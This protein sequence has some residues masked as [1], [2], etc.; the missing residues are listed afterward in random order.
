MPKLSNN[1]KNIFNIFIPFIL[2]FILYN[3]INYGFNYIIIPPELRGWLMM[4][5]LGPLT[6]CFLSASNWYN[7][8]K[9]IFVYSHTWDQQVS[10]QDTLEWLSFYLIKNTI[11]MLKFL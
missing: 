9:N 5:I 6:S 4:S 3:F 2:S 10:G 1:I 11:C 7:W 8:I